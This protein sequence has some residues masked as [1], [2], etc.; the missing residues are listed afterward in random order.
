MPMRREKMT[1]KFISSTADKDAANA[2]VLSV[3]ESVEFLSEDDP[4][5]YDHPS[6]PLGRPSKITPKRTPEEDAFYVAAGARIRDARDATGYSQDL[7]A[8]WF[9]DQEEG[10]RPSRSRVAQWERGRSLPTPP[11]MALLARKLGTT[12]EWLVYGVKLKH[13]V[14]APNPKDLGY[15][16]MPECRVNPDTKDLVPTV[17]WGI[18][19]DMAVSELRVEDPSTLFI[20]R[21]TSDADK[22][23]TGER[24]LI[25]K[26]DV[27]PAPGGFFLIYEGF[28]ETLAHLSAGNPA[29][30][31]KLTV[32][33]NTGYDE[34]LAE[35]SS[36]KIY[37]RVISRWTKN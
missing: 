15:I 5:H 1:K 8:A 29:S 34:Y 16:L 2:A 32:K 17:N 14:S 28:G 24:L 10:E 27:R 31:G 18:P 4:R 25:N 23:K 30:K 9:V 35:F 37:G 6:N 12:P 7:V 22:Y 26:A 19:Y 20:Y 33:V 3:L 11:L 36:L 13:T 21:T